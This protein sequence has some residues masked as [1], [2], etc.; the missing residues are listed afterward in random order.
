MGLRPDF[1]RT[2]AVRILLCTATD[3]YLDPDATRTYAFDAAA[4]I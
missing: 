2:T 4:V 3:V 1:I